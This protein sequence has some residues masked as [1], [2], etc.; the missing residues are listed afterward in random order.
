MTYH[1][2]PTAFVANDHLC[3]FLLAQGLIETTDSDSGEGCRWFTRGEGITALEI[4]V[5]QP[6]AEIEVHAMPAIHHGFTLLLTTALLHLLSVDYSQVINQHLFLMLM[7]RPGGFD[8]AGQDIVELAT[9]ATV[10][11]GTSQNDAATLPVGTPTT[12][13]PNELLAQHLL[14]LGFFEATQLGLLSREFCHRKRQ[15][16]V[17]WYDSKITV[18]AGSKWRFE[19]NQALPVAL[20]DALLANAEHRPLTGKLPPLAG[21]QRT[22]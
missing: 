14:S 22:H 16:E 19:S 17:R 18:V 9:Q 10:W 4:E 12:L 2:L 21:Q 11:G 20:L 8:W 3:E 7:T 1:H 15:L 13:P 6:R 5:S